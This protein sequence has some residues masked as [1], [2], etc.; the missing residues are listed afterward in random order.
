MKFSQMLLVAL[1]ALC[2]LG[3]RSAKAQ[4]LFTL[5]VV[6]KGTFKF[7]QAYPLGPLG[8]LPFN[9]HGVRPPNPRKGEAINYFVFKPSEDVIRSMKSMSKDSLFSTIEPCSG[10]V[11]KTLSERAQMI[12]GELRPILGRTDLLPYL[13]RKDLIESDGYIYVPIGAN[14]R[15]YVRNGTEFGYEW[16]P[17]AVRKKQLCLHIGV[18]R[19]GWYG[20]ASQPINV[21]RLANF[22]FAD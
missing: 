7:D 8:K 6:S 18:G 5:S 17:D 12:G 11:D 1:S 21:S 4:T 20:F 3:I 22:V 15:N 2:F 19:M 9:F 13:K 10:G 14:L 16:V